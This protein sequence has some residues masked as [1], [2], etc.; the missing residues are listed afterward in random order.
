MKTI[1]LITL[2]ALA[3]LPRVAAAEGTTGYAFDLKVVQ[4]PATQITAAHERAAARPVRV[5]RDESSIRFHEP[6]TAALTELK[7]L[8][9]PTVVAAEQQE[10][11]CVIGNELQYFERQADGSFR[12]R[13]GDADGVEGI[14]WRF[15][16]RAA[17]AAAF[18]LIDS[19]MRMQVLVAREPV[20]GAPGLDVG[21]PVIK[22]HQVVLKGERLQLNEDLAVVA[23]D[24][25]EVTRIVY[26]LRLKHLSADEF[27]KL[28][29]AASPEK[30]P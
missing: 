7:V 2:L 19:D 6:G 10:A 11:C 8:A 22:R 23:P 1:S 18:A 15:T 14:F 4:V 26:L 12:L 9:E 17:N 28:T 24:E 30:T 29:R 25:G 5:E 13:A 3:W 27:A 20:E 21:K 16:V